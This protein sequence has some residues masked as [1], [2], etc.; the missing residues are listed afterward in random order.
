M[1]DAIVTAL[2]AAGAGLAGAIANQL[3]QQR[4][5]KADAAETITEAAT[6]LVVELR[7]DLD[8]LRREVERLEGDIKLLRQEIDK[9]E[10]VAESRRL[11]IA[12]LKAVIEAQEIRIHHLEQALRRAGIDPDNVGPGDIQGVPV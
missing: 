10:A 2:I 8:A 4:V 12:R 3:F 9:V 7:V 1:P 5:R 6:R 11:E